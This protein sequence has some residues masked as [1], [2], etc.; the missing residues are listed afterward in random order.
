MNQVIASVI[1]EDIF[2]SANNIKIDLRLHILQQQFVTNT[3]QWVGIHT[4]QPKLT[5]LNK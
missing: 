2:Y 1:E 5:D 4:R 3:R